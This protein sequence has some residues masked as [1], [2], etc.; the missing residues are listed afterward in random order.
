LFLAGVQFS[1]FD[2]SQGNIPRSPHERP[3]VGGDTHWSS[4][5]GSLKEGRGGRRGGGVFQVTAGEASWTDQNVVG[6]TSANKD[7]IVDVGFCTMFSFY[8]STL[9]GKRLRASMCT[10]WFQPPGRPM[11][12][13]MAQCSFFV[14][15][16]FT[17]WYLR[18][19]GAIK[20][21]QENQL[22]CHKAVPLRC[23]PSPQRTV[24]A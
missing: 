14:L 4:I 2:L 8:T 13:L 23:L 20:T 9:S 7:P 24:C 15:S 12:S 11:C 5:G 22:Q 1:L 21:S 10:A 3:G 18:P 16:H 19:S 17:T 6:V